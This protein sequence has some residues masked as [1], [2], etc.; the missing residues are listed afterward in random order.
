MPEDSCLNPPGQRASISP[1]GLLHR[2]A[3][4]ARPNR[5]GLSSTGLLVGRHVPGSPPATRAGARKTEVGV[6]P[7]GGTAGR[8]R[9]RRLLTTKGFFLRIRFTRE[10]VK[11]AGWSVAVGLVLGLP[12]VGRADIVFQLGNNPQPGDE[13]V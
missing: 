9:Y 5:M 8:Q 7:T 1:E 3:A 11:A 13:A 4:S 10:F 12:A 6:A 2:L